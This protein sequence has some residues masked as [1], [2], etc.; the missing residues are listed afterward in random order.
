MSHVRAV[1]TIAL[2]ELRHV[3]RDRTALFFALVLPVLII[4]VIGTTFGGAEALR[5]GVVDHDGS[6]RSADLV[7][8]LD[9]ADGIA[10]ETVGSLDD[11]RREVRAGDVDAGLVVPAGYGERLD[12]SGGARVELVA[13]PTSN[14]AVAAQA[15]VEGT[16]A[17]EAARTA[18][19]DLAAERAGVDVAEAR[20]TADALAAD[21][22]RV[23][24]D[25]VTL[26]DGDEDDERDDDLGVFSYTVPSNLVLFVFVNTVAVGALLA[27]DRARGITH[28]LLATPHG[29]G[30]ILAGIGSAKLLFALVQ[31]ALLLGVGVLLFGVDLGDPLG[32]AL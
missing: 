10:V 12:G 13:D 16:V 8:S 11:L 26:G 9:G 4:L 6:D 14:D 18:A 2:N 19:A 15:A 7:A 3:G 5:L 27:T 20:A 30:T 23:D 29:T 28:R 22:P 24:V 31:S 1:G 17:E 32:A 21:L 25:T